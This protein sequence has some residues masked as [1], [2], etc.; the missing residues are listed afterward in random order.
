MKPDPDASA[1]GPAREFDPVN[2][3]DAERTAATA[4]GPVTVL[5]VSGPRM[6]QLCRKANDAI[7]DLAKGCHRAETLL[8]LAL[9]EGVTCAAMP[10]NTRWPT[11][12]GRRIICWT[13]P[14]PGWGK[15]TNRFPAL[16]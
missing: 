8:M 6:A 7:S 14:P 4:P 2:V 15:A 12:A 3:L 9:M 13:W 10:G 5:D 1:P 11:C 16:R